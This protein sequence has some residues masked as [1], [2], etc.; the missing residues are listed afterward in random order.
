MKLT[1]QQIQ[2]KLDSFN[3]E[4]KESGLTDG[5]ISKL[6]AIEAN[7]KAGKYKKSEEHKRAALRTLQ[8]PAVKAK[9]KDS[10]VKKYGTASGLL[11][12]PKS[13]EASKK[14]RIEKYGNAAGYINT[15]EAK[16]KYKVDMTERFGS[17]TGHMRTPEAL[18][19]YKEAM[20]KR[21]RP[22]LQYDM[23][24]KFIKEWDSAKSA[25]K[26]FGGCIV[27]CCRGEQKTAGGFIWK[28]KN[29]Q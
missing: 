4:Y 1:P 14:T 13:K 23:E 26:E 15:P 20:N 3:K 12:A 8:D 7:K 21:K 25:N 17:I 24:G 16:A 28:Y 22:V 6:A 11:H 5:K 2:A 27:G 18:A 19:K 10:M 9:R 29:E